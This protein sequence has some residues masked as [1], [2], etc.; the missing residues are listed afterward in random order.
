MLKKILALTLIHTQKRKENEGTSG[1][2]ESR[3]Y[4][5]P[6]WRHHCSRNCMGYEQMAG[7]Y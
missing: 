4:I 6:C 1:L 7:Y 2:K 3:M 5:N